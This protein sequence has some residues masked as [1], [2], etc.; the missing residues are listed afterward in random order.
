MSKPAILVMYPLRPKGMAQLSELYDLQRYDTAE[1]KPRFLQEYGKQ[2]V[3]VV[4]NGHSSLIRDQLEYLPNIK[5]VVCSSAGFESID[6][7]A[8]TD[9]NIKFTN[10]SDALYDDVADTALLLSLAC[11]RQL[12]AAH[13][14]VT[15][16]NWAKKG[17]YPLL[18]SMRGKRVGIIGLGMIGMA[19]ARRFEPLGVDIGYTAR[20]PK[21]VNYQR[22]DSAL[23][24]ASWADN[25]IL[26]VPASPATNGMINT[27][28]LEA[29]GPTATLVNIARGSLVDEAAL[30][31]TLKS[32]KLGSAGLDVFASEPNPDPALTCLENVTLYP[33]H[34]SGTVET[35]DAMAQLVVD[36]L[37]AHFA[38]EP[39]LTPV[40]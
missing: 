22:F 15:S 28:I 4:T 35:R 20:S 11:R 31:T 9:H 40:N 14:Y 16:A 13:Q 3:A 17:P 27:E 7:D 24:I 25:L 8:L 1:D 23:S 21:D 36:N 10:T 12:V 6:V 18:S 5:L 26:A 19:I 34:A 2:C 37:A 39:L 33:H 30:I 29:L 32:G 38:G